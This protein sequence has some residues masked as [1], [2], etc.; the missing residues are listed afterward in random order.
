MPTAEEAVSALLTTAPR[1]PAPMKVKK[2]GPAPT[3]SGAP[4][5]KP[6]A[7]TALVEHA[8][9]VDVA[10]MVA[11]NLKKE[12]W[13]PFYLASFAERKVDKKVRQFYKL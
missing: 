4:K 1:V 7:N 6:S 10:A 12:E 5:A 8:S 13:K 2:M 9:E 3:G 11:S